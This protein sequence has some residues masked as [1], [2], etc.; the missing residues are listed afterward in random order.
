MWEL[1]V[2]GSEHLPHLWTVLGCFPAPPTSLFVFLMLFPLLALLGLSVSINSDAMVRSEYLEREPAKLYPSCPGMFSY[3]PFPMGY[4]DPPP[5]LGISVQQGFR[6]VSFSHYHGGGSV[7]PIPT[8]G[9]SLSHLLRCSYIRSIPESH[10][11]A[12]SV[13]GPCLYS[14]HLWEGTHVDESHHV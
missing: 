5:G 7:S 8:L 14:V 3:R 11:C 2:N 10:G 1:F 9:S 12:H 6:H 4:Q 13:P